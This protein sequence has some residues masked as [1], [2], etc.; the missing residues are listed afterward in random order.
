MVLFRLLFFLFGYLRTNVVQQG[1]GRLIGSW[2]LRELIRFSTLLCLPAGRH[3]S[4]ISLPK[5]IVRSFE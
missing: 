2:A 1:N 3:M 4:K 5:G